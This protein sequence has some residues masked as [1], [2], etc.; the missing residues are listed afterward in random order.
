MIKILGSRLIILVII[1]ITAVLVRFYNLYQ[2]A[3]FIGDQGWFYLSARDLLIYGKIPLV[4]I[5]SSHVWLHQGPLWTY[6]LAVS[7]F[8]FRF[9]PLAGSYVT[10]L[11][12]VLTVFMLYKIGSEM[13]SVR[14]GLTA[15]LLYAV[16]PLAVFF[17]KMAFD[18]GP[19]PFFVTLLL[20]SLFKWLRGNVLYFPFILFLIAV[21]YNL[22]L[23]TFTLF[24][25]F[26]LFF[27][28]G[29]W[30]K[31]KFVLGLKNIKVIIYSLLGALIPML[32]VIIYDFSHGFVQTVV[33]LGWTV[34]KP[35][36]VLIKHSSGNFITNMGVVLNFLYVNMG[37]LVFQ[38]NYF[39]ANLLL[40][41]GVIYLIYILCK[42]KK[43][44]ISNPL[45][46]LFFLLFVSLA[47]IL[48]NQ[49]PSDAYLPVIFPFVIFTVAVFFEFLLR[50]GRI[51]YFGFLFLA[52]VVLM[53]IYSV[54]KTSPFYG[55]A[56]RVK[57][58][59]KIISLT[60]G[61]PYNLIGIGSGSQFISYT[62]NY[63]YLLWWMGY[64]P[65]A[66]S[67]R[68]KI[69]INDAPKGII[70]KRIYD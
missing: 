23:A 35:F 68:Q 47:G 1:L 8:L 61:K 24:F 65:A 3:P 9:N 13:F 6:M 41:L 19:I 44:E 29:L 2:T 53:N 4:G 17:D 11:F 50:E 16:S 7:L 57:A 52:L 20:F 14:V 25:P 28:Y 38:Y 45:F 33:F 67:V 34:Y 32:P 10:I 37:K 21:L 62:M 69:I 40:A 15:A 26:A 39:F 36:S 22:E 5:T 54:S 63:Q 30:K 59:E 70:I 60:D 12:G 42:T 58:A 27:L 18:P 31:K 64:P 48:V 55:L 66:K 49:T 56:D 46:L 43:L 51:K